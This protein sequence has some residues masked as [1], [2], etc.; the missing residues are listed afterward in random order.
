M[1]MS[2]SKNDHRFMNVAKATSKSS[3]FHGN[4]VG[5]CVVFKGVV[6]SVAANSEKTHPLQQIYNAT[7][8]NLYRGFKENYELA[9]K[10]HAEILAL[11]PLLLDNVKYDKLSCNSLRPPLIASKMTI[12]VYRELKN[13]SIALSKPC[14]ACMNVIRDLGIGYIVYT[15]EQGLIKE[16]VV[17]KEM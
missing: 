8:R 17:N 7:Y 4:H 9:S 6:V 2:L 11:V 16:A 14:S 13:G 15:D 5:C 12:Y 10:A 3:N 1:I